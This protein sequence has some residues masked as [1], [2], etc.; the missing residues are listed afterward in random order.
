[1]GTWA[2]KSRLGSERNTSEN[3]SNEGDKHNEI[4][5]KGRKSTQ[6]HLEY[7]QNALRIQPKSSVNAIIYG[8]A[9]SK[10]IHVQNTISPT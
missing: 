6:I 2:D 1:M 5:K 3:E 4:Q 8:Y 10:Q 9:E 7:T